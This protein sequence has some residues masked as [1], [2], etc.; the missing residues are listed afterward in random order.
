[1][2]DSIRL[3]LA[4]N[5]TVA[6][7]KL[8]ASAVSGSPA[9]MA[10]AA[11]SVVDCTTQALLWV[12]DVRGETR[13]AAPYRW[14]I[15][16]GIFMFASGGVYSIATGVMDLLAPSEHGHAGHLIALIVLALATVLES[17]SLTNALRELLSERPD[18][19]SV[20]GYLRT[21]GNTGALTVLAEDAAD[22][23]G[24]L[25]AAG[26]VGVTV[27]FG[28][29]WVDAVASMVVGVLLLGL[30]VFLVRANR[31]ELAALST[32][33]LCGQE[34]CDECGGPIVP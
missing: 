10:E 30:S 34:S 29:G 12:G 17:V 3:A 19:V 5:G 2:A 21:A 25:I 32:E 15:A 4:V 7:V 18:G 13:P 28:L 1:M 20:R 27:M 8:A 23:V 33:C 14:G 26:G 31:R 16:A 6:A 11:H 9:M 22:I 24:N